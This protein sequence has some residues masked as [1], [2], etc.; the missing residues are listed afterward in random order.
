ME[1]EKILDGLH[2]LKEAYEN[3]IFDFAQAI[4]NG[5]ES[6]CDDNAANYSQKLLSGFE[7]TLID[8]GML[9]ESSGSYAAYDEGSMRGGSMRGNGMRGG[10]R[11]EGSTRMQPRSHTTGRFMRAYGNEPGGPNLKEM[12][13]ERINRTPDPQTRMDMQ[14]LMDSMQDAL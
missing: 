3:V 11:A 9:E 5:E 7:K 14:R 6:L 2:M 10:S 12:L 1:K 4:N 13:Q 8:I